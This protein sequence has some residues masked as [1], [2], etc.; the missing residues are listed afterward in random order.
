M[1]AQAQTELSMVEPQP[2]SPLETTVFYQDIGT[3]LII[4]ANIAQLDKIMTLSKESVLSVKVVTLIATKFIHAS[5]T[6]GRLF[7]QSP[8]KLIVSCLTSGEIK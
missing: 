7:L 6:A 1:E 4:N 2:Q 5:Q 8:L 3:S